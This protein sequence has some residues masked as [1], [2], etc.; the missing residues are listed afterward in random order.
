MPFGSF[1]EIWDRCVFSSPSSANPEDEKCILFL[2][3]C[4]F[5]LIS[6][7]GTVKA[8]KFGSVLTWPFCSPLETY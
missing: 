4:I 7:C 2:V 1:K 3:K 8:Y 6:V 5:L